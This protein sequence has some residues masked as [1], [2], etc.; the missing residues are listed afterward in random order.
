MPADGRLLVMRC[1]RGGGWHHAKREGEADNKIGLR[2]HGF[3]GA[4]RV[5]DFVCF[6]SPGL[7]APLD[8][9][10]NG[11]LKAMCSLMPLCSNEDND[12]FNAVKQ[13]FYPKTRLC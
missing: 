12:A 5:D 1:C 11:V 7:S 4:A 10:N 6:R 8:R 3:L 2:S 9:R 13:K